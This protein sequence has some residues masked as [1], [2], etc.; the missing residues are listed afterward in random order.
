MN[1]DYL[2]REVGAFIGHGR[3]STKWG[4]IGTATTK[5]FQIDEFIQSGYRQFLGAYGWSFLRPTDTIVTVAGTE[6]YTLS[7]DFGSMDGP[8]TFAPTEATGQI[9]RTGE[10]RI[11]ALRQ[12]GTTSGR[13][14]LAAVRPIKPD[15]TAG[16]RFQLMLW[17]NPNAIY[18]L[19]V[20][21]HVLMDKL[22]TSTKPHPIGGQ[23]FASLLLASCKA[24]AEDEIF[25]E[26]NKA[27][28]NY[29]R[30]LRDAV[31][32]DGDSEP[33]VLGRLTDPSV[34]GEGH[35]PDSYDLVHDTHGIL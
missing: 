30:L 20:R 7:D 4:S 16:Q 9:E 23:R 24:M 1:Y 19:T 33:E 27:R 18:T 12:S 31:R 35:A 11:R 3:D 10:A 2:A 22:D 29:D 15:G 8:L 14:T 17:P 6:D 25:R 21:Y 5:F 26:E 13:P 32:Q 28:A 34:F